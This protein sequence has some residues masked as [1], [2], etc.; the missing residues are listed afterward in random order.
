MDSGGFVLPPSQ[1]WVFPRVGE[2]CNIISTTLSDNP[3]WAVLQT[4]ALSGISAALYSAAA[5][6][7]SFPPLC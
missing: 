6:T 4:E 1:S 3:H 7:L 5:L 2:G